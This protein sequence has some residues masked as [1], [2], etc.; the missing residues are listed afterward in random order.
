[1]RTSVAN[2]EQFP[3]LEVQPAPSGFVEEARAGEPAGLQGRPRPVSAL[4]ASSMKIV[5]QVT[6]GPNEGARFEFE[7]HETLLVGRGSSARLRLS[8]DRHFSRHH[9]LLE[10]LPPRCFLRDLGSTNGTMLNGARV[11]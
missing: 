9:F 2:G 5:L 6:A 10:L 3:K 4:R 11:T 7:R 1:M 8:G